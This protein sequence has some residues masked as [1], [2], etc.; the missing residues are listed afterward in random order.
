MVY[1]ILESM[2]IFAKRL[3]LRAIVVNYIGGIGYYSLHFAW[4]LLAFMVFIGVL[5]YVIPEG[6]PILQPSG[7][8]VGAT[9]VGV[10]FPFANILSWLFVLIFGAATLF[11]VATLP[12]WIGYVSRTIPLWILDQ[13]SWNKSLGNIYRAKQCLAF[14]VACCAII[15]LFKPG[16]PALQNIEFFTVIG[17]CAIA[18]LCFWI[19]YTIAAL[20]KL[21]QRSVY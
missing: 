20:W 12:Y 9:E 16:V 3:P 15:I 10:T 18:A 21:P 7:E 17:F 8:I 5:Q 2:S 11:L 6:R 14:L 4:I 13:T 1:D 19:Q